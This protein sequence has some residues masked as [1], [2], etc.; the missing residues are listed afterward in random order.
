MASRLVRTGGIVV[1]VALVLLV[2]TGIY[3]KSKVDPWGPAGREVAVDIPRGTST[4]RIAEELAH[5]GVVTDASI[6]RLYLKVK[7][8][9]PFEAGLYRLRRGSSMGEALAV[10]ADGPDLPPAVYITVPEGLTLL[11]TAERVSEKAP[12]LTAEQFVA[13]ARSGAVRSRYQAA[14]SSNLE[15]FLFPETYR[16]EEKEDEAGVVRRM[17]ATFDDIAES[18]GYDAT[19]AK[20]GLTPYETV[21]VASLIEAEAKSDEDRAKISRVIYNR[22]AKKMT[23]GIDATFYYV[24][25]P[26][27]KGT[28]LRRSDLARDTPYNTRIH[29]GLV[30]T[31]I[32]APSRASLAAALNPE[33]GPWLFYVLKDATTHAF[34]SD[35]NQFLR[36]KNAAAAKG[37]L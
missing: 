21:I 16:V 29:A 37:L 7:G 17:V 28:G 24:L 26:E 22:L 35:Y 19:Q 11:E 32:M 4:A 9:G 27:R 18:V 8:G 30:P 1:A 13:V 25:P 10:L 31:P 12:H 34:S 36:D 33:P 5:K 6:F 14:G 20:V 2:G 23:L 3:L 15:G